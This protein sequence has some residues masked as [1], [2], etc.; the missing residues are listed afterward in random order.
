MKLTII[1]Y[2]DLFYGADGNKHRNEVQKKCRDGELK[3]TQ[4]NKNGKWFIDVDVPENVL[5]AWR[6]VQQKVAYR[7]A[8]FNEVRKTNNEIAKLNEI[9]FGFTNRL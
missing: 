9:V 1:E 5:E 8:L 7:N 2:C 6:E 4:A 3:A